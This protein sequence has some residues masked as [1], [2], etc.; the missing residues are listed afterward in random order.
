MNR[1]LNSVQCNKLLGENLD[2]L[3]FMESLQE[4]IFNFIKSFIHNKPIGEYKIIYDKENDYFNKLNIFIKISMNEYN[5]DNQGL[6]MVDSEYEMDGKEGEVSIFFEFKLITKKL[7]VDF[8]VKD[9]VYYKIGCLLDECENIKR[10]GRTYLDFNLYKKEYDK[11]I[12]IIKKT[13]LYPRIKILTNILELY[14]LTQTDVF[15]KKMMCDLEKSGLNYHNL[16]LV[17]STEIYKNYKNCENLFLFELNNMNEGE[18][19]KLNQ[20]ITTMDDSIFLPSMELSEFN[21]DVYKKWLLNW[22]VQI[23]DFFTKSYCTIVQFFLDESKIKNVDILSKRRKEAKELFYE[24]K[25][26]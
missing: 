8:Q 4:D 6:I 22:A 12:E 3:K 11:I 9:W 18:L 2:M 5:K 26:Q 24:H 10:Y 23:F 1:L 17:K 21:V 7:L 13:Y 15:P 20:V 14:S 16:K 25:I 19:K